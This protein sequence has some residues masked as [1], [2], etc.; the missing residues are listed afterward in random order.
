MAQQSS[1]RLFIW[2]SWDTGGIVTAALKTLLSDAFAD[3]SAG[4]DAIVRLIRAQTPGELTKASTVN[5]LGLALW[6]L[7]GADELLPVAAAIRQMKLESA[8]ATRRICYIEPE[9]AACASIL[10]EAGAQIV[11]SQIPSLQSAIGKLIV[12]APLSPRGP[13]PITS[14][15]EAQLPWG[16]IDPS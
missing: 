10:I 14:G 1:E 6:R 2:G 9:A 12:N 3:T 7:C 4:N 16:Q 15:L 11:V 8:V 5:C 13:H